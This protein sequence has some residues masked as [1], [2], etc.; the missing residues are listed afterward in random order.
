LLDVGFREEGRPVSLQAAGGVR[1]LVKGVL[2]G[3]VCVG[4]DVFYHPFFEHEP[5]ADV[6]ASEEA[7]VSAAGLT[8]VPPL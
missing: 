3:G 7:A 1:E 2:V 4:E 8:A 6:D 5:G